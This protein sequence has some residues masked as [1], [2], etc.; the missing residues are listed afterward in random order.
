LLFGIYGYS[1]Y[2]GFK[3]R[4]FIAVAFTLMIIL[5]SLTESLLERNKGILLFSFFTGLLLIDRTK[6]SPAKDLN[7]HS[8]SKS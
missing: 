3:R 5:N 2:R 7:T 4:N 8:E 1:L 6:N